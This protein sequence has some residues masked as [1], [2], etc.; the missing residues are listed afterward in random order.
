L[1]ADNYGKGP[2]AQL[3]WQPLKMANFTHVVFLKIYRAI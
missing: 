2:R 3:S 1:H